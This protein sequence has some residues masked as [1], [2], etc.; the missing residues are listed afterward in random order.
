ML[1]VRIF[2][3]I[4]KAT[5]LLS[6]NY[7][8]HLKQLITKLFAFLFIRGLNMNITSLFIFSAIALFLTT[9]LLS[10]IYKR[11]NKKTAYIRS[12][13]G[14]ELVLLDNSAFAL[15]IL[16]H[17]IPVN[18][19]TQCLNISVKKETALL[20]QD[21]TKLDMTIDFYVR[22]QAEEQHIRHAGQTL[23]KI[24]TNKHAFKQFLQGKFINVL[25]E[26]SATMTTVEILQNQR[27]FTEK[28][29]L[30]LEEE[31]LKNSLLLESLAI[32]NMNPTSI[33]YYQHD[34]QIDAKGKTRLVD[35][36]A[37][38]RKKQYD[39]EQLANQEIKAKEL[40]SE[41]LRL[42][43]E[44]KKQTMRL[45]QK[46]QIDL[47]QAA[48][49]SDIAKD[50]SSKRY[51]QNCAELK[52]QHAIELEK[53]NYET[54]LQNMQQE[55]F[56]A[57]AKVIK[58]EE[59]VISAKEIEIAT[60]QNEIE[61]MKQ[62]CQAEQEINKIIE[63]AKAQKDAADI[64][65]DAERI[66]TESKLKSS[67]LLTKAEQ[68]KF[69][70]EAEGIKKISNAIESLTKNGFPER[71]Q[72]NLIAVISGLVN[73]RND[74]VLRCSDTDI[75]PEL[76]SEQKNKTGKDSKKGKLQALWKDAQ[77]SLLQEALQTDQ[78]QATKDIAMDL[79]GIEELASTPSLKEENAIIGVQ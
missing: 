63:I 53:Q 56:K 10:R 36:I 21:L 60:R 49:E 23:G 74:P 27:N 4:I 51:I 70:I 59:S 13:H 54:K 72:D 42:E 8:D 18:L 9:L 69:S 38:E 11:A 12:G 58:A 61:L 71:F 43:M 47:Y 5:H 68:Q 65:A 14:G 78:L 77:S 20:T 33:E 46:K 73:S 1:L 76:I 6:I 24:T 67:E 64:Y 79:E 22:V 41:K 50:I 15:P 7:T 57:Q 25:R 26:I 75:G 55:Q 62:K 31:L 32:Q 66:K 3:S 52:E 40:Q 2:C 39:I 17:V 28:V 19:T 45:E 44:Q 29:Q 35:E 34:N 48:I 37:D 30:R 16:H